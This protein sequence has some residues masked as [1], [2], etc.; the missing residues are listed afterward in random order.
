MVRYFTSNVFQRAGTRQLHHLCQRRHR[1]LQYDQCVTLV[2][3]TIPLVTAHDCRQLQQCR[4]TWWHQGPAGTQPYTFSIDGNFRAAELSCKPAAGSIRLRSGMLRIVNQPLMINLLKSGEPD[5]QSS[6]N[7]GELQ[8]RIRN[9]HGNGCRGTAPLSY[10]IDGVQ[11]QAGP[12][13]T[14]SRYPFPFLLRMIPAVVRSTKQ[15][16]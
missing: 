15:S 9:H 14:T 8:Q 1:L 12:T 5:T 7:T 2:A 16:W 4:E 3:V 13:R 6:S 10:S 11:F